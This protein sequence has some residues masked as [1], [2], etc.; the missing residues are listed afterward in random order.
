MCMVASLCMCAYVPQACSA[1]GGLKR[2]LSLQ[3]LEVYIVM[4]GYEPLCG[5]WELNLSPL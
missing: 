1:L 5:Y 4:Y 3:E 2:A